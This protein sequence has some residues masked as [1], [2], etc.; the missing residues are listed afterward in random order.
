MRLSSRFLLPLL[1]VLALVAAAC[2]DDD[3]ETSTDPDPVVSESTWE[4]PES[5]LV[6]TGR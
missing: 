3:A 1:L 5:D 6:E 2:G 4:R